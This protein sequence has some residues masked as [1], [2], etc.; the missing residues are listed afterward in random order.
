LLAKPTPRNLNLGSDRFAMFNKKRDIPCD[1]ALPG[2]LSN[3][4]SCP[5]PSVSACFGGNPGLDLN[6]VGAGKASTEREIEA[7]FA[8][9]V[10]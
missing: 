7:A 2:Y 10:E 4:V 9:L 3:H 5:G 6:G 8:T 1:A